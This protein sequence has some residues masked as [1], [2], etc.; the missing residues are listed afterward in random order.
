MTLHNEINLNQRPTTKN[1]RGGITKKKNEKIVLKM[2]QF[3][4]GN[5][6]IYIHFDLKN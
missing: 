3:Q 2:S 6:D 4:F 1:I 5:L